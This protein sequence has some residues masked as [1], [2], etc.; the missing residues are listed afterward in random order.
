MEMDLEKIEHKRTSRVSIGIFIA[1]FL[2]YS[3]IS[4]TKS[5]Y[6]ASIASL[7]EEGVFTKTWA[8]TINAG[9]YLFYGLGQ[10]AGIKIIDKA[11]PMKLIYITL[12]GTFFSMIGMT[13]VNSF[14]PML[15][16]WSFCGFIQFPIWPAILRVITE[17]ILPEHKSKAMTAISFSFCVGTL[18]NYL[19]AAVILK[20]ATWRA[21]FIASA[22]V[23]IGC[24]IMLMIVNR[25]AKNELNI[26]KGINNSRIKNKKEDEKENK[27]SDKQKTG[28]ITI[29]ISSGVMLMLLPAFIR[30]ALDSGL[31]AW[32]P[33]LIIENYGVSESFASALTTILVFVNITGVFI[34]TWICTKI[35]HNE[36]K[37]FGLC[38]L[39]AVPFI[40]LLLF[41]ENIS[42]AIAVGCLTVMTTMMYAGH[43]ISNVMMPARFA[44]INRAGSIASLINAVASFGAV[45]AN[46]GFGFLAEHYGWTVTITSWI[47]IAVVA[48]ILCMAAAPLW[49]KFNQG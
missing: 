7:L 24:I 43:Q 36:A 40:I 23:V 42:L 1:S 6:S 18:M 13:M 39:I 20:V 31:K 10:I 47:V 32:V 49:K 27:N 9:F 14:L 33:T 25:R 48:F 35:T 46:M 41:M 22:V 12:L 5:A 11:S 16:I 34:A 37:A 44:K 29:I 45:I 30:T 28:F 26:I 19:L 15:L 17:Y 38:F 3:V 21:L 2:I 4:M 8:G